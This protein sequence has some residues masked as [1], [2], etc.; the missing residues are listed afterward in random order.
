[1]PGLLH[2][3]EPKIEQS[4]KLYSKTQH[5]EFETDHKVLDVQYKPPYNWYRKII[6][7]P[8]GL[9]DQQAVLT[10]KKNT[11]VT[12]VFSTAWMPA[13]RWNA[14]RRLKKLKC[15]T[16]PI[17]KQGLYFQRWDWGA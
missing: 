16:P 6:D 14:I 9:A 10:I 8:G 3:A 15:K 4:E 7:L 12:K 13:V 1:V 5:A 17:V 2:L 11:Y